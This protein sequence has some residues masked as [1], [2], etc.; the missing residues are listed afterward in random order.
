MNLKTCPF[1][2]SKVSIVPISKSHIDFYG[3]TYGMDCPKH[4]IVLEDENIRRL[5]EEWNKRPGEEILKYQLPLPIK[6]IGLNTG[7]WAVS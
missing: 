2:N 6:E 1:C 5:I 3:C 7:N 4:G